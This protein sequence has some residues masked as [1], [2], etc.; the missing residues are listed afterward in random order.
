MCLLKPASHLLNGQYLKTTLPTSWS[1]STK[2]T[3]A[4][5]LSTLFCLLSPKTKYLSL[6]ILFYHLLRSLGFVLYLLNTYLVYASYY[7]LNK[8]LIPFV[9][10]I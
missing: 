3:S 10:N 8:A 5:R 4:K 6:G 2:P 9:I 1:L 7:N